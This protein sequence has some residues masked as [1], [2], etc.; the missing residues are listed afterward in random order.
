MARCAIR[1]C[2]TLNLPMI[3]VDG[4][5]LCSLHME[6]WSG[7]HEKKRAKFQQAEW[8]RRTEAELANGKPPSSAVHST[9]E[10]ADG[11]NA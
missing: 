7:S 1:G 11:S 3:D 10:E 5:I 4:M 9:N 6:D 2:G 8:K